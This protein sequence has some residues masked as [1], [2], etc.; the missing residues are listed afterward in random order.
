MR[1]LTHAFLARGPRRGSRPTQ[2]TTVRGASNVHLELHRKQPH[3]HTR[4]AERSTRCSKHHTQASAWLHPLHSFVPAR[5]HASL[6]TPSLATTTLR[7]SAHR[8]NAC[9]RTPDDTPSQLTT[10]PYR[11]P[12]GP[13]AHRLHRTHPRLFSTRNPPLLPTKG[14]KATM[15]LRRRAPR[16]HLHNSKCSEAAKK[17]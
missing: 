2:R 7:N 15:I 10:P 8:L 11:R 16:Q 14:T 3:E 4:A 13:T 1:G 17:N 12:V 6:R 9:P 5:P